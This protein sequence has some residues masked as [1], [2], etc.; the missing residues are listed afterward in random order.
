MGLYCIYKVIGSG[1]GQ[2]WGKAGRQD[3]G[4]GSRGSRDSVPSSHTPTGWIYRL[5]IHPV[6]YIHPVGPRQ[7]G[8]GP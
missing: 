3:T 6:L 8:W 4:R 1:V 7:G 2:E 5:A